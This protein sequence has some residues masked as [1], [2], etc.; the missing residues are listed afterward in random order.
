MSDEFHVTG[1]WRKPLPIRRTLTMMWVENGRWMEYP[2]KRG[3]VAGGR[4]DGL[5]VPMDSEVEWAEDGQTFT[6]KDETEGTP[7]A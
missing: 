2:V 7:H 6:I 3:E 1:E 4:Y 5:A